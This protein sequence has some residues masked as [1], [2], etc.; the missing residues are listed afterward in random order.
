MTRIIQ[1]P[2]RYIQGKGEL[3][4]LAK[5]VGVLGDSLVLLVDKNIEHL[6]MP[7]ISMGLQ[8]VNY[9]VIS[10]SGEC[11]MTQ[12][13]H[14]VEMIT[15]NVVIGIGGGKTLDVAKAVAYYAKLPVVI[16]PTVASSDAPCSAISVL[17]TEDGVLDKYL[18]LDSNPNMV[19]VD[20]EVI[21]K[22]PV[23]LLV[24]GMGDAL[25][26]YFE[27]RM[28]LKYGVEI[29][30]SALSL[31]YT[32]YQTLLE[33]GVQACVDLQNNLCTRTVENIIEA[34]IYLSGIGFES[35]GLALAHEF[36]NGLTHVHLMHGEKVA[37]GTLV[38]LI[39]END[40][41]FDEVFTFCKQVH[42]PTSLKDLGIDIYVLK[43]VCIYAC[44]KLKERLPIAFTSDDVYKSV[45][46]LNEKS[47]R[48]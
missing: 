40:K 23:R 26:T 14:I 8:G 42:L 33:D 3:K 46:L 28:C 31:A 1:S 16:V 37:F 13:Q 2:S 34:N 36:S 17:Y 5:Y 15:G 27:A 19:I 32:C 29:S 12:I 21:S 41:E 43:E 39:V 20:T 24:A 4:S 30:K 35:G 11:C 38:Q 6:V 22:A 48:N 10:F 7:K 44:N 45:L 25:S 9:E 18:Y 47:I